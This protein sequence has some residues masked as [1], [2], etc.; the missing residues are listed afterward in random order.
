MIRTFSIVFFFLILNLKT[1]GQGAELVKYKSPYVYTKYKEKIYFFQAYNCCADE[2]W[3]SDGTSEGT[4]MVKD[5]N[6]YEYLTAG[7]KLKVVNNTLYFICTDGVHGGELFKSDGTAEGTVLVKDINIGSPYSYAFDYPAQLIELNEKLYFAA[8]DGK[9][10][11][12]LWTSD[13][14]EAGTKMVKDISPGTEVGCKAVCAYKNTLYFQGWNAEKGVFNLWKSDG[15]E[16]GTVPVKD[17]VPGPTFDHNIDFWGYNSD[18]FFLVNNSELW[19]TDGTEVG[20]HFVKTTGPIKQ[21][22]NVTP[23]ISNYLLFYVY[24]RVTGG[25]LWK[26]DG[27]E[28][29][30]VMVKNIKGT[31]GT[32][33]SP[34]SCISYNNK[35]YFSVSDDQNGCELWV[36]N[37]TEDGTYLLKDFNPNGG[38]N[39]G[40]FLMYN[41]KIYFG[42]NDDQNKRALWETDG[43]AEGTIRV[44]NSSEQFY[45]GAPLVELNSFLYVS[46]ADSFG[47]GIWK[48]PASIVS[49]IKSELPVFKIK[50]S[51]NPVQNN[52]TIDVGENNIKGA[53]NLFNVLG[54]KVKEFTIMQS[55]SSEHSLDL[56][57]VN[58]GIY[59]LILGEKSVKIVKE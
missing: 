35:M 43:T 22:F 51:P 50:V 23:L 40:P 13:G 54:E 7:H 55:N 41:D 11:I 46:A 31:T 49:E 39:P 18:V 1:F 38:G 32:D 33:P 47:S 17:V 14:T 56:T 42:A 19:K 28:M 52:L 59:F 29:G 53:V 58:S 12:E 4:K 24:D 5:I 37:G 45:I 20:T 27:T 2:L 3:E 48:Y 15:T 10:G 36:T 25:Q 16:E 34:I 44:I 8:D 21:F 26:T 9:H 6:P 57:D 30:T